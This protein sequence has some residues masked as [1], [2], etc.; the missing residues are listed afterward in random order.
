M[1]IKLTHRQISRIAERFATD[2]TTHAKRLS[3]IAEVAGFSTTA[4]MMA[5]AKKPDTAEAPIAAS[6]IEKRTI[7]PIEACFPPVPASMK[8]TDHAVQITVDVRKWLMTLGEKDVRG[9]VVEEFGGGMVSDG[10]LEFYAGSDREVDRLVTYLSCGPKDARGEEPGSDTHIDE[11]KAIEFLARNRPD[12]RSLLVELTNE[13][14]ID[15]EDEWMSS[16]EDY[17][18]DHR[19]FVKANRN[20]PVEDL[21]PQDLDEDGNDGISGGRLMRM[22]SDDIISAQY[23]VQKALDEFHER[24]GIADLECFDIEAKLLVGPGMYIGENWGNIHVD[25]P[26]MHGADDEYPEI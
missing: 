11:E 25:H 13:G 6:P 3:I 8:S 1:T 17:G 7:D 21:D 12:L 14:S 5:E 24:M 20:V 15:I 4:A 19:V 10:A 22:V 23:A 16:W 2:E 18:R 26:G 9:L